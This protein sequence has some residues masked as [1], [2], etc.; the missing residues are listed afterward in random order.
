MTGTADTERDFA[1]RAAAYLR[2]QGLTEEEVQQALVAELG[3]DAPEAQA[4]VA[5]AEAA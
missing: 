3:L 5:V 4:L 1:L 2:G